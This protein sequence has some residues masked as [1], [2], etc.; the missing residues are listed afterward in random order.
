MQHSTIARIFSVLLASTFAGAGAILLTLAGL[1]NRYEFTGYL[2]SSGAYV[3]PEI[4]AR[5]PDTVLALLNGTTFSLVEHT[6][7][8]IVLNFWATWCGPCRAEM[9]D[10]QA[11]AADY[12]DKVHIIG[13]NAGDAPADIERWVRDQGLTFDIALDSSGLI[14]ETYRVRG[15]PTTYVIS[16]LGQIVAIYYGPITYAT[17]EQHLQ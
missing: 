16:P 15:L 17:I 5:A 6:G 1:P 4:G 9:A 13:I 3:A 2:E 14:S 12:G 10:L 7:K 8:L 11:I